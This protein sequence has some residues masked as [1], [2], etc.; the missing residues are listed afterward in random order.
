MERVLRALVTGGG[1]FLGS[2]LVDRLRERGDEVIVP[3][4]AEYD[5]TDWSD[6]ERLFA[7][8]RPEIVYHLAAEV[9]GIGANQ[10]NP[11]RYWY[12][13]LMMGAHVLELSRRHDVSKVLVAGTVCAYP[14][15]TETPFS[16]DDLWNG[17]PEETNAPYGVAKKAVLVGAQAYREQYGLDAVFLLPAN[18][19]GPRDNFDLE[20]SHVIPALVR[21]ML[22]GTE[23]VTLWGDGSPTREFLYVDDAAEAFVLAADRYSEP[24]PV[25]IGTGVEISIRE[26]AETIADLAGFDGEID[27]D[28][29]KPNGQPR[30]RLDTS[31]ADSRFG[32]RASTS[33]R[34]GLARTIAWYRESNADARQ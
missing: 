19:Y 32:F 11:G 20:T 23:R 31:R 13:N 26:L 9:G 15:F 7:E 21:K 28:E 1:G 30:R 14:K 34:D 6:A 5:L 33:L 18:L 25:N 17:Y 3:R 8:A 27:W 29:T 2:H 22:A 16:E 24:D 4:R 12:A 10:A